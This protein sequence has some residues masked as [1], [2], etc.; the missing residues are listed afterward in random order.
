MEK[1][2]SASTTEAESQASVKKKTKGLLSTV[3]TDDVSKVGE[4]SASASAGTEV[5]SGE[6]S[7]SKPVETS[8]TEIA[9]SG[10][11]LKKELQDLAENS[12]AVAAAKIEGSNANVGPTAAAN[13]SVRPL[14][15]TPTLTSTDDVKK[16]KTPIFDDDSRRR[17][18]NTVSMNEVI[19]LHQVAFLGTLLHSPYQISSYSC[20]FNF[21]L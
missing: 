16:S 3:K 14:T 18:S 13:S 6:T 21:V 4:T 2:A 17:V 15:P 20:H 7:D 9:K 10:Q 1:S 12:D 19:K 11:E 5:N 8:A